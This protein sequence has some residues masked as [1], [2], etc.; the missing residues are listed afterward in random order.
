M[1]GPVP[2]YS[3]EQK[4]FCVLLKVIGVKI[5]DVRRQYAQKW[6]GQHV[7]SKW[8]ILFQNQKAFSKTML[9]AMKLGLVLV[10][11]F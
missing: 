1:N 6:Q 10:V 5:N 8:P 11:M 7:P 9:L 2:E 3:P 4:F